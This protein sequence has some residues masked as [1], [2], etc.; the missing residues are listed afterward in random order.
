MAQEQVKLKV[1]FDGLSF[2]QNVFTPK[3]GLWVSVGCNSVAFC[4]SVLLIG[5]HKAKCFWFISKLSCKTL[6]LALG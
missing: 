3:M 1:K 6:Q 2:C 4:E 5:S